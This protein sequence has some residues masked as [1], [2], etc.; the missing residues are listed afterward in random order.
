M[1]WPPRAHDERGNRGAVRKAG[2]G[3]TPAEAIAARRTGDETERAQEKGRTG[4]WEIWSKADKLAI[5]IAEGSPTALEVGE[6]PLDLDGFFPCPRPAFGTTSTGSLIPVPDYIYYQGQVDEI[7][8]LTRRI[9]KLT[10]QLKLKGFYP[11]GQGDVSDAIEAA[12]QTSS[13][14]IMVPVP[15]WAA[16]AQAGGG[17]AVVWLP[18]KEV[19][20]VLSACIEVRKQI[21]EDIY[22][23]TGISDIV[24]GDTQASET[25]TAQRIKSQWGSIRIRDRQ[26]ELARFA[27]DVVRIAGEIVADLFQAPTLLLMTDMK[28][29]TMQDKQQAQMQAQQV[30][31]QWQQQAMQAQQ[32]GQQPPPEPQPPKGFQEMMQSPTIDEVAQLL[33]NDALR[34]FRIDIET[35]STI[36]P[37]ED[38]EKQRRI[39][40]VQAVGGF[41]QQAVP[42]VQQMPTLVPAIGEIILFVARGF[43]AG[44]QLENVLEQ[45]IGQTAQQIMAPKPPPEPSP[46]EQMRM[47][48]EQAKAKAT[49][50]T[51]GIRAEAEQ[52]KA[53]L[54]VRQAMLD[55]HIAQSKHAMD[56][57]RMR[58]EAAHAAAMPPIAPG[59]PQ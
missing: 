54:G 22:Q 24:R 2:R 11:A 47:A 19:Q 45:A 10:D 12:L 7:D 29:P 15:A 34:G 32:T 31:A 23:I 36:E 8:R 52:T 42:V 38:A 57:E 17:D 4:V 55:H 28:L 16:F 1:G 58:A 49:I 44:R 41:I 39:E 26:S 35:D 48:A 46:D 5:W 14:D 53:Q 37:D 9:H 30:A 56:M 3:P 20:T 27:R 50:Q 33:Q 6:P 13:D 40:F 51:A 25:A 59:G 43:R 21:I 18:I